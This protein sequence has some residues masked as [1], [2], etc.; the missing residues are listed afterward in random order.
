MYNNDYILRMIEDLGRMLRQVFLQEEE[1]MFEIVDEEGRFSESD[2]LGY[3][4][5]RLLLERRINEA[6]NLLF[7]EIERD[8]NP[9]YLAVGVHFYEDL[10]ELSDEELEAADFS[11]EEIAEGL[12]AL[13]RLCPVSEASASE[14]QEESSMQKNKP[15]SVAIDGPSGAGKST[16]ARILAKRLGFLYVDTGAL[17]RA[18]GYFMLEH[19]A[20]P[21]KADEVEPLL[22]GLRVELRHEKGEQKVCVNGEDVTGS[23]RTPEVSMAASAVSA[24]PAV[25]RFLF[26]LQQ[27]TAAVQNVIMDGRDIGTVVLPDARLKIFLTASAEDRAARRTEELRQKG[28]ETTFDEVL[29]DMKQRD[30]N[31]ENRAEAPLRA[32]EDAVLVDTTG[33]TL[34]QSVAILEKLVRDTIG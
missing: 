15:V 12:E 31:D 3:R 8:P 7:D 4:V 10:Q 30:Y 27:D 32:A 18:V 13:Q 21:S 11:R 23:I 5:G 22:D 29:A 28:I 9:S 17:Y 20:D 33:N 25:R 24:L 34:E 26:R 14:K 19:G 2:F 16:I 6:E 1:E